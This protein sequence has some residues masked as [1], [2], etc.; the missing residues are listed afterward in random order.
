VE[1]QNQKQEK[2]RR[3]NL[4]LIAFVAYVIVVIA[5]GSFLI[6][7]LWG[8]S[9]VHRCDLYF[10]LPPGTHVPAYYG[11]LHVCYMEQNLPVVLALCPTP[12]SIALRS[13]HDLNI[14]TIRDAYTWCS[15]IRAYLSHH[16]GEVNA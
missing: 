3:R 6:G 9:A 10:V 14:S 2:K 7:Y 11:S 4:K 15:S 12:Y 1:N 5:A 8:N 13:F 16:G